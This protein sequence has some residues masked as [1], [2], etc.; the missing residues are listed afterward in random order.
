MPDPFETLGLEARFTIE[1][2]RLAERHLELSKTL[3]PDRF[4][5]APANERRMALGR[6]IEVNEAFRLLRNPIRRAEALIRRAGLVLSETSEPKPSP[7]LLMDIMESREALAEVRAARDAEALARL[8]RGMEQRQATQLA[9]LAE[10]LD[11]ELSQ[12]SAQAALPF[13]AELRYVR[14]FL[15]EVAAIEDEFAS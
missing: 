14:R 5:G 10:Q 2:N 13:L 12:A 15:D 11:G 9:R 8:A 4:A 7:A 6:A 1:P 3:H